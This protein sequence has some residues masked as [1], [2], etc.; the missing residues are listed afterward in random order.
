[1]QQSQV[2]GRYS[3]GEVK[4]IHPNFSQ[5]QIEGYTFY[6]KRCPVCVKPFTTHQHNQNTCS[7][8]CGAVETNRVKRE[9]RSK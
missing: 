3:T 5:M 7:R 6:L 9:N 2:V 4:D 8:R 1:M